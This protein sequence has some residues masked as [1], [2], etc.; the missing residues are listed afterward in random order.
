MILGMVAIAA[1]TLFVSCAKKHVPDPVPAFP[2]E[3]A[4]TYQL[5]TKGVYAWSAASADTWTSGN[6]WTGFRWATTSA[7]LFIPANHVYFY[8]APNKDWTATIAVEAQKYLQF[9]VYGGS[10]EGVFEDAN[11]YYSSTVSGV[12]DNQVELQIV[13]VDTPPMGSD[14]FVAQIYITMVDQTMPLANITLGPKGPYSDYPKFILG[15]WFNVKSES[16]T[17]LTCNNA[18]SFNVQS[19]NEEHD[20]MNFDVTYTVSQNELTS[21]SEYGSFKS[22]IEFPDRDNL[23]FEKGYIYNSTTDSENVFFRVKESFDI[24]GSYSSQSAK[25]VVVP[26]EGKTALQ[27]PEGVLYNGE[28]YISVSDIQGVFANGFIS[29][30]TFA[31]GGKLDLTVD[32]AIVEKGYALN[33]NDLT[34]NLYDASVAGKISATAFPNKAEDGLFVI[35]TKQEAMLGSILP[36]LE[37]EGEGQALTAEQVTALKGEFENTFEALTVILALSKN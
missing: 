20:W 17:L 24:K 22:T 30:A 19:T 21:T 11:Y 5:N 13:V 25:V 9:R 27:L 12:R 14:P 36:L 37:T 23:I 10:G 2:R 8:M 7:N 34:L 28:N 4:A 35:V 16:Y 3:R 33:G 32:G 1:S 26:A 31:E 6:K 29:E 15:K 18:K